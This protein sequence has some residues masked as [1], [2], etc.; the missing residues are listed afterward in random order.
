MTMRPSQAPE[1]IARESALALASWLRTDREPRASDGPDA[2]ASPHDSGGRVAAAVMTS[3]E[4]V[5]RVSL[6][7]AEPVQP[8]RWRPGTAARGRPCPSGTVGTGRSS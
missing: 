6:P 2:R 4:D 3:P 5:E 7:E 8:W 1:L